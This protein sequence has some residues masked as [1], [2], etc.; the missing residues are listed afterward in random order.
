M[1]RWVRVLLAI[2][3]GTPLVASS[4]GPAVACDCARVDPQRIVKQADA[5]IA[6]RVLDV[7]TLDPT[8]TMSSVEVDGVYEGRVGATV[9]VRSDIGPAGGSD[10]T[11]LYPAGSR[12]DP[13]VLMRQP[14]QTYVV[15]ICAMPMA[16]QVSKLLGTARPPPPNGPQAAPIPTS[17]APAPA[18]AAVSHD[19]VSWPAVGVGV[20]L[21][22]AL[23]TFA[24]LRSARGAAAERVG[25]D[26]DGEEPPHADDP[27][28]GDLSG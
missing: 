25:I 9:T 1:P 26:V 24:V 10:C 23:I 19:R 20:L 18:V 14:D 3:I 27:P 22:L 5:I 4:P 21:A 17:A 28:P 2:A 7:V 6:G 12:I 13:L 11:V 16:G 8:R 15:D